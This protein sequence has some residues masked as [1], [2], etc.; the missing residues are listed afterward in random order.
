MDIPRRNPRA[1]VLGN[2]NDTAGFPVRVAQRQ[3]GCKA[4]DRAVR[5]QPVEFETLE[6]GA[7]GAQHLNILLGRNASEASD[8]YIAGTPSEHLRFAL[9]TVTF[10]Q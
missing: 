5:Q 7:P 3:L 2:T 8:A 9:Q 1:H 6:D 10:H 4:P